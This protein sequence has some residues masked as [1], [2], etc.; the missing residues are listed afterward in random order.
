MRLVQAA[1]DHVILSSGWRRRGLAFAAG[2]TGALTLA[3]LGLWPLI[4]VPMCVA[5][6]LID[7][8]VGKT[9]RRAIWQA[10]K[11]GW[12]WGFGFHVAG[13]W[14]LGLAFLVEADRFA[15]AL[16][17]GVL[18]F[19]AVLAV[20]AALAFALARAAWS[21]G[22]WRIALFAAVLAGSEVLRGTLF[23]GFPWNSFGM[24]LAENAYLAQSASL[25][26]LYGLTLIAILAGA[27]PA[28]LAM[29]GKRA[30]I[31]PL[32]ALGL[33][34][35]MAAFG[36]WRIPAAPT[37]L[38]PN[39]KLRLLQPN[40]QQDAKF[41]PENG[42]AILERYLTLSD[43]A[44]GP[45][46]LG[47]QDVTHLI[48]PESAFP[49]LLGREPR[50]LGRITSVLPANVTL[51]TGAARAGENLLPGETG[52]PIFNAIQVVTKEGGIIASADKVHLVPF[53][54]YLPGVFADLIR[55]VGLKEF[56]AIP[57]GFSAGAR[58]ANLQVRGLPAAAPLICY[59]VIFPG[60]VVPEGARAG[61]LLNLTNDG[62]FGRSS[63]PY[64]HAAQARLR[65]IEEGLPLVRV[66]NTGV[67]LV[68]DGYGRVIARLG[69]GEEG[70]VDSGLPRALSRTVYG[71]AG[72][73][74][75]MMALLFLGGFALLATRREGSLARTPDSRRSKRSKKKVDA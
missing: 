42:P 15:W 57:G 43:R 9:R 6:W 7:G 27:A 52:T 19:P 30:L 59:E 49:F 69:L 5:I 20:Y 48:W 25:V 44:T 71:A 13:L 58:R 32:A 47:L 29:D 24:A 39:V 50:A 11:D 18:A 40:L 37:A 73:Y 23:T 31:W 60:E 54:E 38:V 41:H 45:R 36:L 4:V 34:G 75:F 62:W 35:G 61:W 16:P 21:A 3:P 2:A 55:A 63:G 28:T 74:P 65:A 8:A 33:L 64:Q 72:N 10:A 51:I 68:S 17:F 14:W 70:V 46:T 56:V 67:S 26:G 66:A 53:G 12:W 22:P 1:A